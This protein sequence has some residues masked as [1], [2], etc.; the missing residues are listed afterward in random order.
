METATTPLNPSSGD[1]VYINVTL[2][3]TSSRPVL[4]CVA[5]ALNLD[6]LQAWPLFASDGLNVTPIDGFVN[7]QLRQKINDVIPGFYV[8]SSISCMDASNRIATHQMGAT[9]MQVRMSLQLSLYKM[10]V[11]QQQVVIVGTTATAHVQLQ[12]QLQLEHSLDNPLTN[13][14]EMC[15]T[16]LRTQGSQRKKGS[17]EVIAIADLTTVHEKGSIIAN[18]VA[19]LP[20]IPPGSSS[21]NETWVVSSL[22]CWTNTT[23]RFELTPLLNEQHSPILQFAIPQ[24]LFSSHPD[25]SGPSI[26]H[27]NIT[28][29]PST[30]IQLTATIFDES[31]IASAHFGVHVLDSDSNSLTDFEHSLHFNSKKTYVTA[32]VAVPLPIDVPR[33]VYEAVSLSNSESLKAVLSAV[34]VID[35]FGNPSI[36]HPDSLVVLS[37]GHITMEKTISTMFKQLEKLRQN[38]VAFGQGII[39]FLSPA[40]SLLPRSDVS[41][42]SYQIVH[43][44]D[45]Y[46][47]H[48]SLSST[49]ESNQAVATC[50]MQKKLATYLAMQTESSQEDI[51]GPVLTWLTISPSYTRLGPHD[52]LTLNITATGFDISNTNASCV[53]QLSNN[54]GSFSKDITLRASHWQEHTGGNMIHF[55]RH[56][57]FPP[58]EVPAST[59][60]VRNWYCLDSDG[61]VATSRMQGSTLSTI[62][63]QVSY[64]YRTGTPLRILSAKML[65]H[66]I[67]LTDKQQTVSVYAQLTIL[68]EDI[69]Y[70][71]CELA[72]CAPGS[73]NSENMEESMAMP[74]AAV[75]LSGSVQLNTSSQRAIVTL[76]GRMSR[77]SIAG[78]WLPCRVSCTGPRG[79]RIEKEKYEILKPFFPSAD[80]S[81]LTVVNDNQDIFPPLL[82][83]AVFSPYE[84]F[85]IIPENRRNVS[86]FVLIGEQLRIRLSADDDASGLDYVTIVLRSSECSIPPSCVSSCSLNQ[87]PLRIHGTFL[88]ITESPTGITSYLVGF[89]LGEV[90]FHAWAFPFLEV[91]DKMGRFVVEPTVDFLPQTLVSVVTEFPPTTASPIP[92]ST[93]ASQ[94]TTTSTPVEDASTVD[95]PLIPIAAGVSG[96]VV[97]FVGVFVFVFCRK[98][99]SNGN[100]STRALKRSRSNLEQ[101]ASR[102][103]LHSMSIRK[104]SIDHNI[105]I[106]LRELQQLRSDSRQAERLIPYHDIEDIKPFSDRSKGQLFNQPASKFSPEDRPYMQSVPLSGTAEYSPYYSTTRSDRTY[107]EPVVGDPNYTFPD[108]QPSPHNDWNPYTQPICE[109]DPMYSVASSLTDPNSERPYLIPIARD[110]GSKCAAAGFPTGES[111]A[112][113]PSTSY[114]LSKHVEHELSGLRRTSLTTD[115]SSSV[116]L[117]SQARTQTNIGLRNQTDAPYAQLGPDHLPYHSQADITM[118]M[119]NLLRR[120]GYIP[121]DDENQ[122]NDVDYENSEPADS[123]Y[124]LDDR[125]EG[126]ADVSSQSGMGENQLTKSSGYVYS[127]VSSHSNSDGYKEVNVKKFLSNETYSNADRKKQQHAPGPRNQKRKPP[128]PV[129]GT[130]LNTTYESAS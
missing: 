37:L 120:Q 123:L 44:K 61:F 53:V 83:S 109:N 34:Y 80:T 84:K 100:L 89:D 15:T 54:G 42:S 87:R 26:R 1:D 104:D 24:P 47:L 28:L 76:N 107:I 78:R 12:A 41:Y 46:N 17:V 5:H 43:S 69:G 126:I 2:Q 48:E 102:V 21:Q 63:I 58:G 52:P 23:N 14:I 121:A 3:L 8:V 103:R 108:T 130:S 117:Y 67:R 38:V 45:L 124:E 127:S 9:I 59:L 116:T 6:K 114:Q 73:P 20:N 96:A 68:S 70:H 16:V 92:D 62:P 40:S 33:S 57:S 4:A 125:Y 74:Q 30:H 10:F 56:I 91:A 64:I 66:L 111:D 65:Q 86:A 106:G 7:V 39:A 105:G 50:D 95:F 94:I 81:A 85:R 119:K 27:V 25:T 49:F 22:N 99:H 129:R 112:N 36:A 19:S 55:E 115:S 79:A 77:Y 93:T 122:G 32:E 128:V 11:V 18:F 113:T 35:V 60:R 13:P 51:T 82:Y 31:G 98:Q 90:P 97:F 72:F 118:E 71:S 29:H 75:V 88:E 101:S 110:I